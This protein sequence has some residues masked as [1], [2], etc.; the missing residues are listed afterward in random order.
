MAAVLT[1]PFLAVDIMRGFSLESDS[2]TIPAMNA[3]MV[4][5]AAC[6]FAFIFPSEASLQKKLG[7]FFPL[8]S[9]SEIQPSWRTFNSDLIGGMMAFQSKPSFI[10]SRFD[11]FEHHGELQAYLGVMYVVKPLE[12]LDQYRI[13][14]VILVESMPASYLLVHTTGWKI[15]KHEDSVDGTYVT[16]ARTTDSGARANPGPPRQ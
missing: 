8:Q 2:K 12:L 13:D 7:T 14:H 1:T 9:I 6:V 3:L 5:C 4:A 15:I 11:V 16:F 10:D